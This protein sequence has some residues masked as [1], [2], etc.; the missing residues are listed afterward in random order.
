MRMVRLAIGMVLAWMGTTATM[1]APLPSPI[2]FAPGVI[3]G[4]Q[5]NGAPTFTPDGRIAFFQ[6]SLR[7]SGGDLE[8]HRQGAS[9]SEPVVASFSGPYSDC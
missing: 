7:P 9:W 8:S 3:S 5:K 4:P 2:I 6:R 1:A